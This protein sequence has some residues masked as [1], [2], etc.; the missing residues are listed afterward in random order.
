MLAIIVTILIIVVNAVAVKLVTF[1]DGV[2]PCPVLHRQSDRVNPE[3]LMVHGWTAAHVACD[4]EAIPALEMLLDLRVNVNVSSV[5]E[6]QTPLCI[7]ATKG[8]LPCVSLLLKQPKLLPNI[9]DVSCGYTLRWVM[10]AHVWW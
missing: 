6:Q 4:T 7:A 10:L 3:R 5:P 2:R 8:S 9:A 1:C